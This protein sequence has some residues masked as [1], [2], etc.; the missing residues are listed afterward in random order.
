MD[1]VVI[2]QT[3]NIF[4]LLKNRHSLISGFC[5][6]LKKNRLFF[7]KESVQIANKHMIR[8]SAPFVIRPQFTRKAYNQNI[9]ENR[10]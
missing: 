7:F 4:S 10:C 6:A 1:K 5:F 3:L 2:F 9:D 8:C